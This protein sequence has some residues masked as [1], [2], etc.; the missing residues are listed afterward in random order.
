MNQRGE[1]VESNRTGKTSTMTSFQDSPASS[2]LLD[3][4][5]GQQDHDLDYNDKGEPTSDTFDDMQRVMKLIRQER[6]LVAYS[7][8]QHIL[9]TLNESQSDKLP[10]NPHVQEVLLSKNNNN[11]NINIAATRAFLEKHA[12]ELQQLTQHALIFQRAKANSATNKDWIQCHQ[13]QN[14]TSS[15]RREKD[16]SLSFKVEGEIFGLPLFEQVAIM[17]EVDLYHFWAPFVSKSKKV[18]S[19]G[20]KLD[21]VGWYEVGTIGMLRDSCYRAIG[22]DCMME[23]GD[24]VVVAHGLDDKDDDDNDD[25]DSMNENGYEEQKVQETNSDD[26]S[27]SPSSIDSND[28]P[29]LHWHGQLHLNTS[30]NK[31]SE[32][33]PNFLAR[34]E[35]LNTINLPPRPTGFNK[36]RMQL[37]FFEAV[38]QIHSP[39]TATTHL[40]ANLDLKLNFVPQFII[41]FIMKHMCGLLLVK[42][43]SAAKRALEMPKKSP[44]AIRMRDDDFYKNWLLPKFRNYALMQGWDI[45]EVNALKEEFFENNKLGGAYINTR[46]RSSDGEKIGSGTGTDSDNGDRKDI[47]H[48]RRVMSADDASQVSRRTFSSKISGMRKKLKIKSDVSVQSAPVR[49]AG[50]SHNNS[51]AKKPMFS[52][53]QERRLEELRAFRAEL[54]KEPSPMEEMRTSITKPLRKMTRTGRVDHILND[55]SHLVVLPALFLIQFIVYYTINY[56]HQFVGDFWMVRKVLVGTGILFVFGWLHWKI[57]ETVCISTFDTIDLPVIKFT[58]SNTSSSTRQYVIERVRLATAVFS[59]IIPV[60]AIGK[61]ITVFLLR[62]AILLGK[63]LVAYVAARGLAAE[64]PETCAVPVWIQIVHDT[65]AMMAYSAVFLVIFCS[66]AIANYPSTVGKP[67]KITHRAGYASDEDLPAV[68][69]TNR[70]LEPVSEVPRP[71]DGL[72]TT[73]SGTPELLS[74]LSEDSS[75][76]AIK[77]THTM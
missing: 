23:S 11:N 70:S 42:M 68:A 37:K 29:E 71:D 73:E 31:T 52:S 67:I 9:K 33:I 72:S 39:T 62:R 56:E 12:Q 54:G 53:I 66:M 2:S 41:D 1:F 55:C 27:I 57:V 28:D 4:D 26:V 63:W 20:G 8:Y 13:H 46:T 30:N 76:M 77:F 74:P 14:V 59:A 24:I 48:L 32:F 61:G 58:G 34:E 21:Q 47:G 25:N 49:V 43:Q 3:Q 16:N 51:V 7:L 75:V 69:D 64:S 35:I 60:L 45:P 65:R 17:R 22:C 50:A 15:Y 5:Q 19:L 36:A 10:V 44:H 18:I 38:I 40:V 6:H